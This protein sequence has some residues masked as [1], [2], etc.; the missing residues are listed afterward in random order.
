MVS[1]KYLRHVVQLSLLLANGAINLIYLSICLEILIV[2]GFEYSW[3]VAWIPSSI[4]HSSHPADLSP[5]FILPALPLGLA[6]SPQ[7]LDFP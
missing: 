7:G 2:Q 3:L 6:F 5:Y 1:E 4:S